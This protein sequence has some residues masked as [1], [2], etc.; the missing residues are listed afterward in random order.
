LEEL[1]REYVMLT[2]LPR[3]T[4]SRRASIVVAGALDQAWHGVGPWRR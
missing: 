3:Y 1:Q 4:A 2:T